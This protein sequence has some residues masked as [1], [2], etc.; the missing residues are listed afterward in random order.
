MLL[1]FYLMLFYGVLFRVIHHGLVQNILKTENR[2]DAN[3]VITTSCH[4]NTLQSHQ[5]HQSWHHD[6]SWFTI[7][8]SRANF[9][10]YTPHP[11]NTHTPPHSHPIAHHHDKL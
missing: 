5:W 4:N 8:R 1:Q 2:H 6:D 3:F 7:V 11:T 10:K 9:S